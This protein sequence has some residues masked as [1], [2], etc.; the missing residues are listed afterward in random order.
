MCDKFKDTV[1]KKDNFKFVNCQVS[2]G[3]RAFKKG[4]FRKS[5]NLLTCKIYTWFST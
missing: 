3:N 2:F 1:R 5:Y 4:C